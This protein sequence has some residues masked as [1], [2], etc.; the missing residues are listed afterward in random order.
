MWIYICDWWWS[1]YER[2]RPSSDFRLKKASDQTHSNW[3]LVLNKYLHMP[4][5][6]TAWSLTSDPRYI[7]SLGKRGD[8]LLNF[9][10]FHESA[11]PELGEC[12]QELRTMWNLPRGASSPSHT[13]HLA[14]SSALSFLNS[15]PCCYLKKRKKNQFKL[16][17]QRKQH[18]ATL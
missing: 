14:L 6:N 13:A 2:T 9:G 15:L 17:W 4:N 16:V 8:L 7:R 3:K 11:R 5:Q 10:F 18:A 12:K 1:S